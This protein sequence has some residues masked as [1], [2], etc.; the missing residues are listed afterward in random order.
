MEISK[1]K[2]QLFVAFEQVAAPRRRLQGIFVQLRRSIPGT[3]QSLQE[4]LRWVENVLRQ[5]VGH[6]RE[7]IVATNLEIRKLGSQLS[8][9]FEREVSCLRRAQSMLA[10]MKRST[11]ERLR[12]LREALRQVE[13]V[14]QQTARNSHDVVAVMNYR[15]RKFRSQLSTR[16]EHG[17]AHLRRAQNTIEVLAKNVIQKRGRLREERHIREDELR[18]LLASSLDA[19]VMTNSDR[20]LVAANSKCLE[21]FGV[22]E[23]NLGEFTIDV[24][25]PH[26]HIPEF[27]GSGSPFTRRPERR[28]K[29]KIRRLDGS[30]R[31]AEWIFVANFV[32]FQ[33]LC[34]FSDI[35]PQ[36]P[37]V[38]ICC[39]N[40]VGQRQ[41]VN[42]AQLLRTPRRT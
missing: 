35:T 19:I 7:A 24:F 28:G 9:A 20:R 34:R 37:R 15:I 40:Q 6:S 12:K 26:G 2:S 8:R 3:L 23:K 27:R 4:A 10:R 13:S 31:V 5:A 21:L 25:L 42:S 14:L 16:L 17:R 33:H 22:S 18:E 38:R 29:C 41:S 32:P 11:V 39:K 1:F 30:M 36:N